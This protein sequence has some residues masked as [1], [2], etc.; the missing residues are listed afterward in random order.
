MVSDADPLPHEPAILIKMIVELRDENDKLRAMLETMKRALYGARSEKFDGDPAQLALGLEDVSMAPIEP[1]ADPTKPRPQD[2]PTRRKA[3]RNIG[4][5]PKHLPRE[6]IVIEPALDACPCCQGTLHRIGEDVSEMLDVVPAII[7][8]KRIRRPRYGCRAC[9]GAVVQA[10]APPRPIEG[11]LPTTALLAHIAA[12]KFAWHLPLNRQ[13]QMLAGHG[14]DLDRSTLVHWIERTVWWLRPLHVLL[15]KT[16]MSAPKVFCDDTPLP[17]LDRTRRRTRIGRL[18]CYAVDD[19]P[20]QGP[21]PPAVVYLYADDRR[22][23]HVKEHLAGFHGVLQVDAYAGYDELAKPNR[24]GGAIT[25]AYCLAHARR[26]FFDV[27]KQ[28]GDGVAAEALRRIGEIYAIEA[29]IRG[30][31]AEERVAVRQA[32]TKPLMA[33]LWSWLMERLGEISAKSSLAGAIRYALGHWE[34]LTVFLADG[35]VEVDS[36]IVE[37]SIRPIPLG[38]KNAL[39]AGSREGG[40]RW[41][42]L[43]S[44]VNTAKLHD[45]DPQTYLADAL[46]RIV[47]G[48]IKANALRELLPWEW[49]AARVAQTAVAA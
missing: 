36:N 24:P 7:R 37:R 6:D 3:V 13:A 10:P 33:A 25:L 46:D 15:L 48:R 12:A 29:A 23:R 8:V 47:S 22:G 40:E 49:K 19:R 39:F 16:V 5:L 18:W 31:T 11:G 27:H 20:W 42:I 34:G 44:L 14:I 26:E 4:G 2:R 45:I 35:R 21:A 28:T 32:E 30:R 38:R 9:E 41:A 1:S 43:A 17:V